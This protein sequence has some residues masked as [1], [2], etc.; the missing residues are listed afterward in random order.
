MQVRAQKKGQGPD[1]AVG[2]E[3]P[4]LRRRVARGLGEGG[5][6]RCIPW[7]SGVSGRGGGRGQQREGLPAPGKGT[8]PQR[9]LY[10]MCHYSSGD[11]LC[12]RDRH[13]EKACPSGGDSPRHLLCF[14]FKEDA[15]V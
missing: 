12:C 8:L 10:P 7:L 6:G 2:G 3:G 11:C 14:R 9:D 13:K 15:D 5:Q 4:E 1:W